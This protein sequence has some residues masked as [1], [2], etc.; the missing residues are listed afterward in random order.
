MA[1]IEVLEK[2]EKKAKSDIQINKNL[3]TSNFVNLKFNEK[4]LGSIVTFKNGLNYS[5]NSSG[6]LI[7]IVGVKDFQNYFSPDLSLLEEIQIDG[8]L[9]DEYSLMPKDILVVRSNGSANLVGRFLFIDKLISRTSFSGFTIRVRPINDNVDPK[10]LC[11]FL[12]TDFVRNKIMNESGGSN[13]KSL[14]QSL[15]SSIKIPL[16]PLKEQQ[17]LVAQITEIENKIVELENQISAIPKQ[18]EL[19]F[20]YYL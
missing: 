12:K 7:K 15:L 2:T 5:R 11:Y 13:I 4:N 17:R 9:S 10:F 6:D 18:K 14:N 8:N 1:E 3:I 19:F 20:N 16:P